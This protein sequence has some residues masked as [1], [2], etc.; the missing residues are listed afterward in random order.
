MAKEL[1]NIGV[2]LKDPRS[3]WL[4]LLIEQT[5]GNYTPA[6]IFQLMSWVDEWEGEKALEVKQEE[7]PRL[8]SVPTR[9]R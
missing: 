2:E 7:A 5:C 3:S 4:L 8:A 1:E 6:Q 9:N